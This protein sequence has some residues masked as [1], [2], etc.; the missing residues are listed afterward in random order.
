MLHNRD[1]VIIVLP[2]VPLVPGVLMA[3]QQVLNFIMLRGFICYYQLAN[4][5]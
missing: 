1:Y 2:Q 5:A 4:K 3:G